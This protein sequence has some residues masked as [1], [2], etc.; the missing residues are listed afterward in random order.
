[1]NEEQIAALKK[2]LWAQAYSGE[3]GTDGAY[4]R[5]EEME[6][7]LPGAIEKILNGKLDSSFMV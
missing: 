5:M 7:Y 3:P 2:W 4:L 1:M 6:Q